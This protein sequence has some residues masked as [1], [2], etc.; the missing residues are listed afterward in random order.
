ML[1]TTA[2]HFRTF[3]Q[4][5]FYGALFERSLT[6]KLSGA[7][8]GGGSRLSAY[9][10]RKKSHDCCSCRYCFIHSRENGTGY[11]AV[12]VVDVATG[13]RNKIDDGS[14]GVVRREMI[15]L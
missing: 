9:E 6:G 10:S 7:H 1:T 12:A 15:T 8:G 2:N 11:S 13:L 3:Q 4:N 5:P 14:L